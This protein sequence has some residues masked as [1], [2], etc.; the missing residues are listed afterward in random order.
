[1]AKLIYGNIAS[2]DGYIEDR[3]GGFGWAEPDEEVHRFVNDLERSVGTHLYG[4]RLYETMAVWETDPGLAETSDVTRDYAEIWQS[5]DKI[6][7]SRR[8]QEPTTRRTRI[9]KEF[10]PEEIRRLKEAAEADSG[11]GGA[12]LA[13]TA[14]RAGL[15]DECWLL[16]APVIVGGGKPAL[17]DG[18]HLPLEL[19]EERRFASGFVYVRYAIE[20]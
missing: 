17:P 15:V 1:M 3:E 13:A 10:D 20:R 18:I 2:L 4:R 6:V 11:I 12:D 8:L 9:E 5:A 7:Y 19:L 14:F 16:L